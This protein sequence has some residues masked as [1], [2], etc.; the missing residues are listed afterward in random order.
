MFLEETGSKSVFGGRA[1]SSV[2]APSLN[3]QVNKWGL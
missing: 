1:D 2:P 3:P